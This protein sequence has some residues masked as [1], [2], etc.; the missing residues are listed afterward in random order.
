MFSC[1]KEKQKENQVVT[2]PQRAAKKPELIKKQ[3][4]QN[5]PVVLGLRKVRW[6]QEREKRIKICLYNFFNF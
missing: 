3:S 4:E 1:Y 2:V 5:K 6:W